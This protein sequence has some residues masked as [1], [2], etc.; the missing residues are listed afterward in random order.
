MHKPTLQIV[1]YG[2]EHVAAV[3]AFN[4]RLREG[5]IER[6]QLPEAMPIAH[7][8]QGKLNQTSQEQFLVLENGS[9]VRGGYT[10]NCGIALVEGQLRAYGFLQLPLSEGIINPSY[11]LIGLAILK[12]ALR[13]S[14]LLFG[15]GMGGFEH[16]L[17]RMFKILGAEVRGVPFF[18]RVCRARK[19][20]RQSVALRA[21]PARRWLADVAAATF[22]GEIGLRALNLFTSRGAPSSRQYE[23]ELV[24]RFEGW[25][26]RIW[27][28]TAAQY[29]FIC[30]RDAETLN[31]LYG[32]NLHL[33]VSRLRVS[34]GGESVG[35]A[36]VIAADLREHNHFPFLRLGTIVDCLATP[37]KEDLVIA[38]ATR[39]LEQQKVD[40]IVSNQMHA[41]WG[42]GMTR[43]GFLRYQTNFLFAA[44]RPLYGLLRA[45]D[46]AMARVHLNRGDGDG[47]YNLF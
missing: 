7:P 12:D 27:D 3:V 44:P 8:L 18:F 35:W 5:S 41:A 6:F 32:R 37:G 33:P 13:R 42:A 17:P 11:N 28:E 39:F 24:P 22:T 10:L 38:A 29:S 1:P 16:P 19:F 47:P 30:L 15:L 21:S 26:D 2:P 43:C 31:Y 20:L 25:C 40:L 36:V 34:L 45:S 14:E 23:F 9:A 4:R 46:E